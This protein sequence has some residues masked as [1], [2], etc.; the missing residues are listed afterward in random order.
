MVFCVIKIAVKRSVKLSM[1]GYN[2]VRD[3]A[4]I[5]W[6][7]AYAACPSLLAGIPLAV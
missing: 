2:A 3:K 7:Y 4:A 6:R 1:F 5:L